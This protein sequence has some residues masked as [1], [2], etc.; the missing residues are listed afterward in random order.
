MK[1]NSYFYLIIS[2]VLMSLS[3][4]SQASGTAHV[5]Q[6][7]VSQRASVEYINSLLP[8]ELKYDGQSGLIF[9][10]L[11][12]ISDLG[13]ELG[14]VTFPTPI[15]PYRE[16]AIGIPDVV[17]ANDPT[18]KHFFF[19][20]KLFL[21]SWA[22]TQIG[23]N[24]YGLNKHKVDSFD[25]EYD[26]DNATY[27]I[28]LV[29]VDGFLVR[30]TENFGSRER[31]ETRLAFSKISELMTQ[32]TIGFIKG[33]PVCSNMSLDLSGA[34]FAKPLTLVW[35][36]KKFQFP[37]GEFTA[38]IHALDSSLEGAYSL[39]TNFELSLPGRCF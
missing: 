29:H 22:A 20:P 14:G 21:N 25:W 35:D 3:S 2:F 1:N 32:P 27:D 11:N 23:V 34:A 24:I 36:F 39:E 19:M 10:M 17:L 9:L 28:H 6:I 26:S 4:T 13:F 18:Q 33:I 8:A 15:S 16:F 5:K 30:A 38:G 31:R 12:D 37:N 7:I